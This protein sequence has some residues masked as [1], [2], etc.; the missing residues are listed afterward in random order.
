MK[1]LIISN[2]CFSKSQN[3]GKTL[4][5]IFSAFDKSEICQLFFYS[6]VPDATMCEDYFRISDY[7]LLKGKLWG[8]IGQIV[9]PK[10]SRD[11]QLYES[12][13]IRK[14][15]STFNRNKASVALA[16][17]I[18][19]DISRWNSE[20]L[21]EW[22]KNM[23]PDCIFFASGDTIFSYKIVA[24]ISKKFKIPVISYVCD[25]FFEGYEGKGIL[26]R[27]YHTRLKKWI[28]NVIG[29][30]QKL[31]VICESLGEFYKK[32]FGC[33]YIV[34]NTGTDIKGDDNERQSCSNNIAYLGNIGL[35][36]WKSLIEIG[37]ALSFLNKKYSK[38]YKLNIY[39]GETDEHIL[40]NL[41]SIDTICFKGRVTSE[42]CLNI[43]KNS[44]AV[45]HTESFETSDINRVKYS[46]STK[47]ADS[48]ASGTCLFAY[49][50]SELASIQYLSK[51]R[52]AVVATNKD[53][54]KS[55][56]FR[57]LENTQIRN[58]CIEQ[59]LEIAQMN[60]N[61]INNSIRFRKDCL[62]I[63]GEKL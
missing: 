25:E 46:M 34:L 44:K 5:S 45:I 16:R 42:E 37:Q 21:N 24:Y 15:Y 63:I 6:S 20:S 14:V 39:S 11:Q 52:C 8:T 18:L 4:S 60:H 58:E 50:S 59:A 53:E 56:L 32:N 49:G 51:H 23:N 33:E 36:R 22:V 48:L 31:A 28:C 7:D 17:T 13:N 47:I 40:N 19:W 43:I 26:G 62:D 10:T 27:I 1:V 12:D 3:M 9:V 57:V 35:N 29:N 61:A 2:N 41:R 30:S 54:L 38:N 55:Q